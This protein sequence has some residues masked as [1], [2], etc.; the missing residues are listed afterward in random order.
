MNSDL[1]CVNSRRMVQIPL[2]SPQGL[3]AG[4]AVTTVSHGRS[5]GPRLLNL[6]KMEVIPQHTRSHCLHHSPPPLFPPPSN[7]LPPR[8]SLG[9]GGWVQAWKPL[10]QG[11]GFK[12]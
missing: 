5:H 1:S 2:P 4:Q 3:A 12:S 6:S 8:G 7:L 10:Y 9:P 11:S